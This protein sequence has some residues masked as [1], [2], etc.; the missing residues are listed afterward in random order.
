MRHIEHI[1]GMIS[2]GLHHLKAPRPM[3]LA[4]ALCD[5]LRRDLNYSL[6]V[7]LL[8]CR[9]RQREVTE[10]MRAHQRRLDQN[11]CAHHFQRIPLPLTTGH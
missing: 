4:D 3:R 7:Q 11:L 10:L 6:G 8:R 5:R 1:L 2:G 9:D